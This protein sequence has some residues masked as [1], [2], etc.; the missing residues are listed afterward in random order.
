MHEK[1]IQKETLKQVLPCNRLL[2]LS[3]EGEETICINN[4]TI[5]VI[6]VWKWLL[7]KKGGN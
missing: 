6:P 5:E 7:G 4:K 3:Y 2:I 1:M